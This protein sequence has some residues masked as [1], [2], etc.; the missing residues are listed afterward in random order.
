[1]SSC[2]TSVMWLIV[3]RGCQTGGAL[4]ATHARPERVAA[5]EARH[6]APPHLRFL[7]RERARV[8]PGERDRVADG[9]VAGDDHVVGDADVPG[10]AHRAADHA[11]LADR[12]AAGDAGTAG[13]HRVRA[14][15]RV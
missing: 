14:D 13:D 11:A 8:Y 6:Q 3:R 1:M 2:S 5:L 7:G 12:D 10:D 4:E 9:R 15:A